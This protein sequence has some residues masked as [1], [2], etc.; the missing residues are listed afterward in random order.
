MKKSNPAASLGASAV[1]LLLAIAVRHVMKKY[2][3]Y[4]I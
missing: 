1:L 4:R 2:G 3:K